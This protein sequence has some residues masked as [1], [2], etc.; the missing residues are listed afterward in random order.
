MK[1]DSEAQIQ[2]DI[3]ATFARVPWIVL[4]RN[5]T[6]QLRDERGQVVTFGLCKGSSDLIGIVRMRDLNLGRFF[7]L[8]VKRP[9]KNPTPDQ[10]AFIDTVHA[11]GGAG[12][13]VTS[14]EEACAFAIIARGAST[15]DAIELEHARL[16][17][18]DAKQARA[19]R[20]A[21]GVVLK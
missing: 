11:M 2:A 20:R 19:E 8:E 16:A 5:N 15:D 12:G 4:W 7:A 21:R 13:W 17:M 14:V 9:G 10:L 18:L 6:G 1:P 3:R